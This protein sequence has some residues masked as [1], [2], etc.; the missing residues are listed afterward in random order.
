M[1]VPNNQFTTY[2]VCI[3]LFMLLWSL[4]MII[5]MLHSLIATKLRLQLYMSQCWS[6][7]LSVRLSVYQSVD[8]EFFG[9]VIMLLVHLCYYYC[10]S[11]Y[12]KNLMLSYFDFLAA[13]AAI[14][15]TMSVPNYR[16]T[17]YIV[18]IRFFMLL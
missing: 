8:N 4:F 10:C 15:V 3:R 17:T 14:K 18:V 13:I 11:L 9:S 16:F 5:L 1:S 7:C 6:D 12:H 2:I